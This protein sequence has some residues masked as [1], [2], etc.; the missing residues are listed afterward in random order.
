V[1]KYYKFTTPKLILNST[2]VKKSYD[3]QELRKIITSW[4]R[5]DKILFHRNY[6]WYNTIGL[7]EPYIYIMVLFCLLLE[8]KYCSY[9]TDAWIPLAY[10]EWLP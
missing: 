10:T 2:F 3:H 4:W 6:G 9:F 8:E 7:R 5:E 1:E